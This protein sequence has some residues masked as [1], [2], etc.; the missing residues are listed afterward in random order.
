M[1]VLATKL[2]RD[3][4][5]TWES[6][7]GNWNIFGD[8]PGVSWEREW[9]RGTKKEDIMVRMTDYLN[10]KKNTWYPIMFEFQYNNEYFFLYK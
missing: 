6:F 1:K 3:T 5:Q 4:E 7:S 9:E 10:R 8:W 2:F